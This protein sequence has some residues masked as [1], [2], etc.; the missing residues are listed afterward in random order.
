MMNKKRMIEKFKG[1][2]NEPIAIWC[3]TKEEREIC[4]N[5]ASKIRGYELEYNEA[6]PEDKTCYNLESGSNM[7]DY[8]YKGWYEDNNYK[9]IPF[10]EFF[11]DE[12]DDNNTKSLE[13]YT[14]KEIKSECVNLILNNDRF[15]PKNCKFNSICGKKIQDWKFKTELTNKKED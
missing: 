13:D 6:H 8:C 9:V 10:S 2:N 5:L 12:L 3:K 15:C 14:L 4:T 11:V 7:L 1:I